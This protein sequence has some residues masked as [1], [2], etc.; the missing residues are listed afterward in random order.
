[1]VARIGIFV[2]IPMPL[3]SS[4]SYLRLPLDLSNRKSNLIFISPSPDDVF[5]MLTRSQ[6]DA[7]DTANFDVLRVVLK[8]A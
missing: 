2:E 7:R 6:G 5:L 8:L 3:A 1:M 4:R